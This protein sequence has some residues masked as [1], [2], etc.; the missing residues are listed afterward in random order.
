MRYISTS[1]RPPRSI[2]LS[3]IHPA[4]QTRSPQ[5]VIFI[6]WSQP[7][8]HETHKTKKKIQVNIFLLCITNLVRSQVAWPCVWYSIFGQKYCSIEACLHLHSSVHPTF[9]I[10]ADTQAY[11]RR[12][13]NCTPI[14]ASAFA[15]CSCCGG[16]YVGITTSLLLITLPLAKMRAAG[17]C[18]SATPQKKKIKRAIVAHVTRL[19]FLLRPYIYHIRLCFLTGLL[20]T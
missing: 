10:F 5:P 9:M 8:R 7:V 19:T 4:T 15:T 3:T 17:R 6:L 12:R 18:R 14:Q 11:W 16:S 13:C 20:T 1:L 2:L